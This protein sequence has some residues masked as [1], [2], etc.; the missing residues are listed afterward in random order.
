MQTE[1]DEGAETDLVVVWTV[2]RLL[3]T[4]VLLL[5]THLDADNWVHVETSQLTSL[6]DSY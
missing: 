6:D 5:V 4:R 3:D 2:S 1:T